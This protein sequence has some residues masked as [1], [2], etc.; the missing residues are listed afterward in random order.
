MS[1]AYTLVITGSSYSSPK[2]LEGLNNQNHLLFVT[3]A[4]VGAFKTF[5]SFNNINGTA[6]LHV[7]RNDMLKPCGVLPCH[8]VLLVLM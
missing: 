8:P 7:K 2:E 3:L 5:N 6:V 1:L 4:L